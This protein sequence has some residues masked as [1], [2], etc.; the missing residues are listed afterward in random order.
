MSE[1]AAVAEKST[2]LTFGLGEELFALKVSN[3]REVLDVGEITHV[4]RMP[5]FMRGVINL[6]GSVVPVVDMRRK[7]GMEAAED[8]VNTCIIVV[9]VDSGGETL[10]IGALA[11]SV[12]AVFELGESEIEPPPRISTD[13]D[14]GHILG[15]GKHDEGFLMI[16]DI[17]RVFSA[18][19][20]S[21]KNGEERE[22]QAEAV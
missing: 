20:L 17:D 9:E 10:I 12:Q 2:Y 21:L 7:L 19:D 22:Y 11:D 13:L 5:D 1:P 8:T 16:L 4:P 14:P 3:V 6:R 15:M 18:G